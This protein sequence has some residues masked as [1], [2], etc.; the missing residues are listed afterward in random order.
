MLKRISSC[1]ELAS[2][3]TINLATSAL[4]GAGCFDEVVKLLATK[5]H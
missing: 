1:F 3:L 5:R 2:V 4:I